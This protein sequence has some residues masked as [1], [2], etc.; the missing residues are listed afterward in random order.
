MTQSPE[1]PD[2]LVK[3]NALTRIGT[4]LE[5]FGNMTDSPVFNNPECMLITDNLWDQ[6][7]ECFFARLIFDEYFKVHPI[8]SDT[9]CA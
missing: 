2:K 3:Q 9:C 6:N 5:V 1:Q 4:A 8:T 7:I